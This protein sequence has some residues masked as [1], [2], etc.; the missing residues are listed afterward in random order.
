MK[1]PLV[2]CAASVAVMSV[3][4]VEA[5]PEPQH[6]ERAAAGVTL[7]IEIRW[8]DRSPGPDERSLFER[9]ARA[10]S[11]RLRAYSLKDREPVVG[12]LTLTQAGYY[13]RDGR[14]VPLTRY[15]EIDEHMRVDDVDGPSH[16][17]GRR[18]VGAGI[19]RAAPRVGGR[20]DGRIPAVARGGAPFP[21]R[22]RG[23]WHH[24]PRDW[25]RARAR[26]GAGLPRARAR[27]SR[28]TLVLRRSA[29]GCRARRSRSIGARTHRAL[30]LS[31][32]LSRLRG[33]GAGRA[34]LGDDARFGI[35]GYG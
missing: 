17:R 2:A 30:P 31:D 13:L 34:R 9:A 16:P 32:V 10:W 3:V 7:V 4:P 24:H 6:R 20:R 23:P 14:R 1:V 29:R 15:V 28:R 27:R 21:P 33:R 11:C 19:D 18:M 12:P 35:R 8:L 22:T 26:D 5:W 25:A